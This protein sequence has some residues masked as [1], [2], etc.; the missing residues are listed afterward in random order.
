MAVPGTPISTNEDGVYVLPGHFWRIGRRYK[1]VQCLSFGGNGVV[2][3]AIDSH[4]SS[5]VVI[6]K[7]DSFSSKNYCQRDLRE[8][9][10]LSRFQKVVGEDAPI[11]HI[12][13][14]VFEKDGGGNIQKFYVVQ[15]AK[16]ASLEQI[17]T[18]GQVPTPSQTKFIMYQLILALKLFHS[19]NIIHR[20]IRPNHIFLN[21][22]CEIIIG[23]FRLAAVNGIENDPHFELLRRTDSYRV[24][25][26]HYWAPEVLI[27]E[28]LSPV[29]D[30]WSAGCIFAELLTGKKLF[31]SS[32]VCGQLDQIFGLLGHPTLEDFD[33]VKGDASRTALKAVNPVPFPFEERFNGIDPIALDFLKRMIVFNPK[34]RITAESALEHPYLAEYH[35]PSD[36]PVYR[37]EI[38]MSE[39]LVVSD[40]SLEV[41]TLKLIEEAQN[42]KEMVDAPS[43]VPPMVLGH[44][45]SVGS[46]YRDLEFLVKGSNGTICSANDVETGERVVISKRDGLYAKDYC[47]R[48]LREI[49]VLNRIQRHYKEGYEPFPRILDIICNPPHLTDPKKAELYVVQTAMDINLEDILK[50]QR[51][52]PDQVWYLMYSMLVAL[53]L[54]HSA[55][56]VHRCLRPRHVL[57][58]SEMDLALC[59]L[60]RSIVCPSSEGSCEEYNWAGTTTEGSWRYLSPEA[61]CYDQQNTPCDIWSAGCIFAEM[62]LGQPLFPADANAAN[63]FQLIF[64]ILGRP[65]E[66]DLAFINSELGLQVLKQLSYNPGSTLDDMLKARNV[67]PQ[68]CDLIKQ[69]LVFDP[70]KRITA[71][72]ALAHPY[73]SKL[74]DLEEE[75]VYPA[76]NPLLKEIAPTTLPTSKLLG[77]LVNE[78][79]QYAS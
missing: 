6:S 37:G 77:M 64:G 35:D 48:N 58:S 5:P 51:L 38:P 45:W 44:P 61:L 46:R 8:L 55:G 47:Q 25:H 36:E 62:L 66:K 76:T 68:A 15:G 43:E 65:E 4:T 56:V 11:P 78:A 13:D 22:E 26:L 42:L 75:P 29:I 27:N 30:I 59:D 2:C 12:I 79:K 50:S 71:E 28:E 57:L 39:D 54:L 73:F 7:R 63:I 69:M 10:I 49:Q 60:R 16:E 20:C 67:D 19:A 40:E 72:Q 1:D 23:D 18:S 14:I 24:E 53:K 33:F 41:L 17:L 52:A 21:S 31:G 32:D 70:S 74:H 3:R 9:Q 34:F